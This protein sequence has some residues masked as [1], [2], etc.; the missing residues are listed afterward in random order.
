[1][2]RILDIVR[3]RIRIK[4]ESEMMPRGTKL[5]KRYCNAVKH[6]ND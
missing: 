6:K 1:M 2:E 5:N 3:R 4:P